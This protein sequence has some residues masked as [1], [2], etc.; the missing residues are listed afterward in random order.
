MGEIKC[1]NISNL[2]KTMQLGD[3]P[4][5]YSKLGASPLYKRKQIHFTSC[6]ALDALVVG[7]FC[8][9][10]PFEAG[11]EVKRESLLTMNNV[12]HELWWGERWGLVDVKLPPDYHATW[13]HHVSTHQ[14]EGVH[15]PP[16]N[17]L[18]TF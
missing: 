1:R 7:E 8:V 11:P 9:K 16:W 12:C 10:K 6:A 13:N 14:K 2:S 18:Y 5:C 15:V 17:T 3:G 4:S